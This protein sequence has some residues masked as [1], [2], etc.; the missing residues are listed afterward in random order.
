MF[1]LPVHETG[2]LQ[3][4][5]EHGPKLQITLYN[6]RA[7]FW[8]W[9]CPVSYLVVSASNFCW[10]GEELMG[11]LPLDSLPQL[12]KP[13]SDPA[14]WG[15]VEQGAVGRWKVPV[16]RNHLHAKSETGLGSN[17]LCDLETGPVASARDLL[18]AVSQM[19]RRS[20]VLPPHFLSF[21]SLWET[22]G[23]LCNPKVASIAALSSLW[24][25]SWARGL[26]ILPLSGHIL[27]AQVPCPFSHVCCWQSWP[28]CLLPL[29]Y[30]QAGSK[31][32]KLVKSLNG[33]EHSRRLPG[34][35]V[36]V[37]EKE[38]A[39]PIPPPGRWWVIHCTA[40]SVRSLINSL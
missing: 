5:A 27:R 31:L 18:L 10:G 34:G 11:Y 25:L 37:E 9:K 13:L 30:F 28:A 39:H 16:S 36:E 8:C 33:R 3:D 29:P 32:K 4:W 2:Q 15:C 24:P 38:V 22:Q 21:H 17:S 6:K 26:V 35:P 23:S 14:E 1:P 7:S 12:S 20:T 40:L 19:H